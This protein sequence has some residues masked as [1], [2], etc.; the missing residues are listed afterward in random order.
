MAGGKQV[1]RMGSTAQGRGLALLRLDRV[2]DALA[3]GVP[4]EADG[5]AIRPLKPDWARFAWPSK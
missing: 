5:I 4:L 1:G 3:A 2:A